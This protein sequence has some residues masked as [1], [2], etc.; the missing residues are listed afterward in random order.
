MKDER[1]YKADRVINLETPT[2][3]G[4]NK[5]LKAGSVVFKTGDDPDGMYIVRKGELTVYLEQENKE[6]I[7]AKIPEGG[8][9]GEMALFEHMPRSATVKAS[10]DSEITHISQADFAALMKQI[11]KWFVGLMGALSG[12]LRTT[13][14]RLKILE[15]PGQA[16][17]G[18]LALSGRKPFLNTIRILHT[19]DLILHRDGLKDGKDVSMPRKN[20]EDQLV[21]IFGESPARV[22]A[23][24]DAL[25]AE[26]VLSSKTD[27]FKHSTL[28]LPNRAL[29]THL[30]QFLSVF[31]KNNPN[32]NQVPE[33][34]LSMT[35]III[36]MA[37]EAPYDTFTVTLEELIAEAGP[38]GLDSSA[39][40][41]QIGLF[42]SLGDAVKASKTSAKSGL[43]L[44]VVKADVHS[45]Q[46]N[47]TFYNKLSASGLD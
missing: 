19:I 17:R 47:I 4:V 30:T 6:I 35:K 39:F 16:D 12:R 22:K 32:L 28:S 33:S 36:K 11:P 46:K 25:C 43:G 3:A 10:A 15:N 27:G 29:L 42:N 7:L 9:V 41:A 26:G 23:I 18:G 44:R 37:A 31:T 38:L 14:D 40:Q 34:A 20:L 45:F 1:P 24:L 13:N 8:I 5:S 2:L 21:Q